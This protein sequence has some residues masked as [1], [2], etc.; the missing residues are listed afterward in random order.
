[1]NY[2][3]LELSIYT[4]DYHRFMANF[5]QFAF[6][7]KALFLRLD[8]YQLFIEHFYP[9]YRKPSIYFLFFLKIL[10]R[11]MKI[12]KPAQKTIRMPS[13]ISVALRLCGA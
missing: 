8:L 1:M 3:E 2:Q 6:K 13:V 7:K 5:W 9:N 12:V 10:V 11:S 4:F